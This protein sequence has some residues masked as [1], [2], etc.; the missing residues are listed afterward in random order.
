LAWEKLKKKY[1]LVST[2]SLVKTERLFRECKL[3]KDEDAE[4]WINNLKGLRLK[5]EVMGLFMTD[6]QFIVQVLNTLT[7][8]YK[9]Q[10]FLLEKR[11]GSKENPLISDDLKEELSLIYEKISIKN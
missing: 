7:N 8:K 11:I 4:T 2:S 5:L 6:Y 1:Y 10:M 9:L 3:G